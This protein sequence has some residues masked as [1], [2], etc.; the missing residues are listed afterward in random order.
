M[1]IQEWMMQLPVDG[2]VL[3]AFGRSS[4]STKGLRDC[5]PFLLGGLIDL[6]RG[7]HTGIS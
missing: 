6:D 1:M 7:I 4:F 3:V 5:A 2:R